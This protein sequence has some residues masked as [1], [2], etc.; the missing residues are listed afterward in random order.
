[1]IKKKIRAISFLDFCLKILNMKLTLGQRVIAKVCYDN[2]N[3]EDLEGE[4][5]EYAKKIFGDVKVISA[6][7]RRIVT[8]VAGRGSGKS[9]VLSSCRLL[10][11]ALTLPLNR[12]AAGEKGYCLIICP[13]LKTAKQTLEFVRGQAESSPFIKPLIGEKVKGRNLANG[14]RQDGFLI[15]RP[16]G[17]VVS[18]ECLAASKGGRS[19]RGRSLVCVVLDECAFFEDENH[20]VNDKEIFAALLPR[21]MKGS[22][23]IIASTPWADTGLLFDLY[24]ANFESPKNSVVA[25]APTLL[26]MPT[27]EMKEAVDAMMQTEPERAQQEFFAKFMTSGDGAW[28]DSASVDKCVDYFREDELPPN[29][30]VITVAGADLAFKQDNAALVIVQYF[31][32]CFHVAMAKEHKPR[33][34]QPLLPS[35]L[36]SDFS[37]EMKRYF[38]DYT[39]ADRF[40]EAPFREH[41]ENNGL[42]LINIPGGNDGKVEMYTRVRS[43]LREGRLSIPDNPRLIKQ[44]KNVSVK[45]TSGGRLTI[46]HHRRRGDGHGDMVSA[47]VA[48]VWQ[49]YK[50]AQAKDPEYVPGTYEWNMAKAR[51][52]MDFLEKQ[53]MDLD[54][55]GEDDHEW[56]MAG[57]G[58]KANQYDS[59]DWERLRKI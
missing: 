30:N 25:V 1:M 40:N 11:L 26:M 34:N 24:K 12:L 29:Q 7:S 6:H 32:D 33:P 21:M 46:E 44:L 36:F 35:E 23:L 13:D 16:D 18:V 22:Q 48:A 3:P 47:L 49:A 37:N 14:I 51:K 53:I 55:A 43:L 19:V 4:E 10:H 5:A 57:Y 41:L 9:S 15:T 38:L 56:K 2:V 45:P 20:A 27:E 58:M 42:Y 8:I 52:Q 50:L 17:Y 31:D 28:F 39:I 54:A 59:I